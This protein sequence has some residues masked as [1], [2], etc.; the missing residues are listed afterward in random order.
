MAQ[1]SYEADSLNGSPILTT[2]DQ[3]PSK[4][5]SIA[6]FKLDYIDAPNLLGF[7]YK[8]SDATNGANKMSNYKGT[9]NNQ[10][11]HVSNSGDFMP[12]HF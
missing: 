6:C 1:D 3:L 12:K 9:P 10:F 4:R 11:G 7:D 2:H 8:E 5:L